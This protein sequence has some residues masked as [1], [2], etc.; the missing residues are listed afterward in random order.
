MIIASKTTDVAFP[1]DEVSP[2][3][4]K[5]QSTTKG[6]ELIKFL[7]N[8]LSGRHPVM[9]CTTNTGAFNIPAQVERRIYYLQVDSCFDEEK[10]AQANEYYETVMQEATNTLFRDFCYRMGE[11]IRHG[12][13]VLSNG[14]AD[15]LYSARK[16]FREYYK[17]IGRD[18][19]KYF[20][21][22]IYQDYVARGRN[23]WRT[24][25]LQEQELFNYDVVGKNSEPTLTVKL[26]EIA[27]HDNTV[28]LNYLRQD[29]LVEEAGVF[30]VLRA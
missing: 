7:S 2:G 4:F 15:Y 17:T 28:Y 19:P 27:N 1:I 14:E 8:T 13:P 12:E 3:F 6:E 16:I 18:V 24:L 30:T 5:S 26:K 10:K 9:I 23:I 20:P 21:T 25:F 11:S 22:E 29:L